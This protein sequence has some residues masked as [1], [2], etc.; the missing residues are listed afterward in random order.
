MCECVWEAV[1][2]GLAAVFRGEV[3]VAA[4]GYLQQKERVILKWKMC[5]GM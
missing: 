5:G 4:V 1:G 3:S 2:G